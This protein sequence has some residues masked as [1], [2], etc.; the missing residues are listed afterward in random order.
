MAKCGAE[1]VAGCACSTGEESAD[2]ADAD[3]DRVLIRVRVDLIDAVSDVVFAGS[4]VVP[5]V[6]S[7]V[8]RIILFT[9]T[10]FG[11]EMPRV[12]KILLADLV[13]GSIRERIIVFFGRSTLLETVCESCGCDD[14]GLPL[15]QYIHPVTNGW[16]IVALALRWHDSVIKIVARNCGLFYIILTDFTIWSSRSDFIIAVGIE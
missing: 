10:G 16:S 5:L 3:A 14:C 2:A 9:G 7:S 15:P 8:I 13:R 4:G 11:I 12:P 1:S 6:L